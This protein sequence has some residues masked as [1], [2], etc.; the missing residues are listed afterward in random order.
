MRDCTD[1]KYAVALALFDAVRANNAERQAIRLDQCS[2][3]VRAFYVAQ[4][5]TAIRNVTCARLLHDVNHRRVR[6]ELLYFIPK[7]SHV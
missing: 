3:R 6:D 2:T 4:A 5:K 7:A 1:V